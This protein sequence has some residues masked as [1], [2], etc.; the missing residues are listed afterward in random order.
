MA[1][2]PSTAPSTPKLAVRITGPVNDNGYVP[3]YVETVELFDMIKGN[4]PVMK[5]DVKRKG[6]STLRRFVIDGMPVISRNAWDSENRSWSSGFFMKESDAKKVAVS[7][8]EED[9][10]MFE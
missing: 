9:F 3:V 2:K 6:R 7:S 4:T 8:F 1:K 5:N 10:D